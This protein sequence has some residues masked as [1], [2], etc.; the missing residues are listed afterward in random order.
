MM[1][2]LTACVLVKKLSLS[3]LSATIAAFTVW[4]AVAFGLT[5]MLFGAA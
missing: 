5:A 4:F 1:Y 2:L 3:S